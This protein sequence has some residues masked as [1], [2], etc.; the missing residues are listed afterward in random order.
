[1][2]FCASAKA[3]WEKRIGKDRWKKMPSISSFKFNDQGTECLTHAVPAEWLN[4]LDGQLAGI[5]EQFQKDDK[6]GYKQLVQ[7][8]RAWTWCHKVPTNH[9][10][11]ASVNQ[12]AAI[13]EQIRQEAKVFIT[14]GIGGSDLGTRTLHDLLDHPYHND[15]VAAG[16]LNGVPEVYF[17]GD[18]F[19]PLRLRGLLDM[20]KARDLL[21]ET[22]INIVSKSGTTA[23]TA[24]AGMVLA[25]VMG[26]DWMSRC[27]AT[28]GLNENSLLY[29]MQNGKSKP[30][31]MAMLPVPDGVG[32]RFSFASP[33]GLL[34]LAVTAK[35]D[36]QKR[37]QEAFE[38][39]KMAHEAFL[40]KPA[41]KNPAFQI[42]RFAHMAEALA[43]KNTLVFYPFFDNSKLGDWFLQLYSESVQERA[44]GLDII[45]TTGPT[46]NHSLLN[47]VING[48]RNKA[49]LFL[50]PKNFGDKMA[51]PA[52]APLEG[53]LKL[54]KG[55]TFAQAQEASFMGTAQ[56]FIAKAVPTGIFE[57]PKRDTA[58]VF[59][60][61]R[62]LMD[63]VAV[64]GRLQSLHLDPMTGER[65]VADEDTYIQNGVEGYKQR[66]RENIKK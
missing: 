38:G 66:M 20:L 8:L 40:E 22:V 63:M 49:V 15:M 50:A 23:E 45:A 53:S 52:S 33:V 36:P 57:F 61:M 59:G 44:E 65:K 35:T 48:P 6:K 12:I 42:A 24:L 7:Q 14:V 11:Y 62:I 31:F 9:P 37:L 64:K 47:G 30:K 17:T 34:C 54:F 60:L 19:D 32:G 43:K 27:V 13:A 28:T 46:G 3:A 58:S 1:M 41:D 10:D 2:S 55:A 29:Q 18:T 56:D 16:K 21:G 4:E 5:Q 39:Y 25:D 51:V 26:D